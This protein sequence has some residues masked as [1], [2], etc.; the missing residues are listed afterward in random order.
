MNFKYSLLLLC[1]IYCGLTGRTQVNKKFSYTHD[2]AGNRYQRV[3]IAITQN[4]DLTN[5]W[6]IFSTNVLPENTDLIQVLQPLINTGS[7]LKVID[8]SGNSIE[9]VGGWINA[10]GNLQATEGYKIKVNANCTLSVTGDQ[11]LL[12]LSINLPTGWSIISFPQTASLNALDVL[13]QLIDT[14]SLSKV[15][16][17]NGNSIEFLQG[18]GWFNDIGNFR[19]GEGYQIKVN[20]TTS[21]TFLENYTK[22]IR[23]PSELSKSKHFIP[24]YIGKGFEHMNFHIINIPKD[25][26]EAGDE[27]SAYDGKICVGSVK[28]TKKQIT[29]DR[30]PLVVSSKENSADIGFFKGNQVKLKLWKNTTNTEYVL[31]Y[32]IL[33]GSDKF[34]KYESSFMKLKDLQKED[35][36]NNLNDNSLASKKEESLLASENQ[37]DSSLKPEILTNPSYE[38]LETLLKCYPNPMTEGITIEFYLSTSAHINISIFNSAGM[39]IRTITNGDVSWGT[40]RYNWDRTDGSGRKVTSGIYLCKLLVDNHYY[41]TKLIV[42]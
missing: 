13:Q 9:N 1:G 11:V 19:P 29:E 32:E 25:I 10:I 4:I 18:Y 14:G 22:S 34:E 39:L 40:K 8:E 2:T 12:P 21:L 35:S 5:G 31:K 24:A 41:D 27:I 15:M 7:L 16:D 20:T 17:E 33:K 36:E 38:N 30:I 28:I 37:S 3:H 42:R 6:N 26:V 23:V